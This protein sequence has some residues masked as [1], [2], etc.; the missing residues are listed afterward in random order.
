MIELKRYTPTLAEDWDGLVRASRN[1]TFLHLRP[2]M[3]YHSHRFEDCSLMA[4]DAKGRLIAVLP[5]HRAGSALASHRGLTYGG[6]IMADRAD[7]EAMVEVW[8]QLMDFARSEGFTEIVYRPVPHIFHRYPAEE[9]IYALWRSG[10]VLDAVQISS[11]VDLAVPLGFDMAGRQAVRKAEAH[12]I[13]IGESDDFEGFWQVL[14]DNLMATHGA[15]PV[16]S[17][18]EIRLLKSRFPDNIRL[19]TATLADEILAGVVMYYTD[20]AAHSQYASASPQGK[21]LRA[22]PALYHRIMQDACD[23]GTRY[24]DFGTS[25]EDGGHYLNLGLIRQKCGFGGR[26]IAFNSYKISL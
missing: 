10:G 18:A 14:S 17:L 21:K 13:K 12:G 26:G 11:V 25:C 7:M 24:F 19:Y 1:G 20:V 8:A 9:D 6:W 4:Y 3:D 2:Y 22:M 15:V 16:H 23:A 5:A